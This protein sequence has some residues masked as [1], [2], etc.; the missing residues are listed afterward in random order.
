MRLF[1][2][3][4]YDQPPKCDRCGRPEAEC[5]CVP[6]AA[7]RLSP[8]SQVARLNVEKRKKGKLVTVIRGLSAEGN[9]LSA[10]L[11]SLKSQCGAGGTIHEDCLEVQGDHVQRISDALRELGYQ[12]KHSDDFSASQPQR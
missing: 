5:V 9:D 12:V 6:S 2:G 1:A 3:T 8:A 4:K 7:H 11:G 10:L